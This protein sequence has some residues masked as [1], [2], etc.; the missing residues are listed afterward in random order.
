MKFCGIDDCF[1]TIYQTLT[2]QEGHI[3]LIENEEGDQTNDSHL[4][5]NHHHFNP[6][7]HVHFLN[8]ISSHPEYVSPHLDKLRTSDFKRLDLQSQPS[9]YLDYT[10]AGLYPESLIE[11]FKKTLTSKVFGNPHSTNPTSQLSSQSTLKAKLA[12]LEFLDADSEIYD[13]VWTSNATGAMRILAE[14]YDF[15]PGQKLIIGTDSHSEFIV[16]PSYLA[17]CTII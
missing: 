7:S 15:Q 8:F 16:F 14:G 5:S 6:P 13:L 2:C 11:E 12:I 1:R 10:G 4:H 9:Y 17:Y 3:Q